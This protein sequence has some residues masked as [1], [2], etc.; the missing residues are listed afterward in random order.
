MVY[1]IHSLLGDEVERDRLGRG[2]GLPALRGRRARG[3]PARGGG[4]RAGR[5]GQ[6]G[7]GRG[8]GGAG[9]A[10]LGDLP[11]DRPRRVRP[12]GRAGAAIPGVGPEHKVVMYVGSIVHPNQGVPILIDALPR[13]FAR[14]PEARCVLVGGPAEA[15]EAYRAR[16][17]AVRRP[18]DRPDRPDPRAGRRADPPRRRPGPP[19]AGLPRELLGPEQDRRLPRRGPAD[20]G[21]RLRRL[22]HDPGRHRRRPADRRRPRA[23]GRGHPRRPDRPRPRRAA[24]G[25]LPGR[26]PRTSSDGPQHRPLPR[27]PTGRALGSRTPGRPAA[28]RRAGHF[29][30]SHPS[31]DSLLAPRRDPR[32]GSRVRGLHRA[33]QA[34]LSIDRSIDRTAVEKKDQ[35]KEKGL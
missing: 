31:F 27:R 12:A 29:C 14:V 32:L 26:S 21:D 34:H 30:L 16:L 28:L 7:G 6:A 22:H 10:G 33:R 8:E 25:R 11:G 1:E 5:A 15:G 9:R 35:G 13:V 20:R 19:P 24:L 18:A 17:G 3:L 2:L 4:H 23:A